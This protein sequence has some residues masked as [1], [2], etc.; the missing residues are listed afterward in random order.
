MRYGFLTTVAAF[1]P[2]VLAGQG[3]SQVETQSKTPDARIDAAVHAAVQAKIP[4][5]LLTTKV[6]EGQAKHVPQDRIANAVEARLRALMRASAVL[7]R[8]DVEFQN[9]SE[10]AVAA[11][12]LEAGVT[13]SALIRL[14][15]SAPEERRVVAVA[16][17]ADLVRLGKTSDVAL[18]Q[19]NAAVSTSATLANLNAQVASQLRLGGLTSTLDAV[20]ILR[21]P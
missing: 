12:A 1:A 2:A 5:S 6:A 4:T 11:D 13:E 19:V 10:L 16:V 20:G 3:Q 17:L 8:A 9:A 15:K 14:E 21:L 18:A 7:N